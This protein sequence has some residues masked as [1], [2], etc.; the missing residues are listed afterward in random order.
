MSAG[1]FVLWVD[2]ERTHVASR[3]AYR[4]GEAAW[5]HDETLTVP[6]EVVDALGWWERQT[7]M[8]GPFPA[9]AADRLEAVADCLRTNGYTARILQEPPR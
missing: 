5:R 7:P 8:N 4:R 2:G 1:H 6:G 9:F 3:N